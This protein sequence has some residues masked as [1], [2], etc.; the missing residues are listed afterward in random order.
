MKFD[1]FI[2]L[3][4]HPEDVT[5]QFAPEDVSENQVSAVMAGIPLLFWIPLVIASNSPY[6]KFCANQGLGLTAIFA[7]TAGAK[8]FL[9][10]IPLIGWLISLLCTAVSLSTFVMLIVSA[11]QGRAR[12][13]PI[14]GDM[15]Q[16]FQ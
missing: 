1:E 16:V 10:W 8:I 2:N 3:L 15:I 9:G 11:C 4:I 6:G 13:I 5:K 14:I 12:K 7:V